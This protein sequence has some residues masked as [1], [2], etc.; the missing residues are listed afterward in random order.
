MNKYSIIAALLCMFG[1]WSFAGAKEMPN[2]AR[3][4][5]EQC[6]GCHGPSGQGGIDDPPLA[7]MGADNVLKKMNAYA[8]G[9]GGPYADP[10]MT[11]KIKALT[12]DERTYVAYY[13]GTFAQ[14][15]N[16]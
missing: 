6:A 4:Y 14:P 16:K 15:W 1:I 5:V 8:E 3:L 7:G 11:A 9:K 10:T 13:I 2:G 12:P